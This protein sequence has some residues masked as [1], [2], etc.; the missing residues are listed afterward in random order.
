MVS[1]MEEMGV[2]VEKHHHEVAPSQHEL[3][4]M[5]GTL[6]ETTD[7]MQL[8]KYAVHNV[9]H[10]YGV[11]ATF[12]PKLQSQAITVQVCTSTSHFGWMASHS[13][14]VMVML[15]F[16]KWHCITSAV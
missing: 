15:I 5:F 2:P 4:V 6:I 8:Y 13:L 10:A 7:N 12:M 3:G 9:A 1:V 11:S 14:L 16:Q